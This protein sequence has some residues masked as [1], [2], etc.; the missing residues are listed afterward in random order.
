MYIGFWETHQNKFQQPK[1]YFKPGECQLWQTL[2]WQKDQTRNNYSLCTTEW[3][4]L[5]HYGWV[6]CQMNSLWQAEWPTQDNGL[7]EAIPWYQGL[8]W[9]IQHILV[10]TM[11]VWMIITRRLCHIIWLSKWHNLPPQTLILHMTVDIGTCILYLW[12]IRT[13]LLNILNYLKKLVNVFFFFFFLKFQ[14]MR[15][16]Y[17][18]YKFW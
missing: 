14:H 18:K 15:K 6:R 8:G 4:S 17:A 5:A 16:N 1:F 7:A 10:T 9:K 13:C 3:S 2:S 11:S 12:L